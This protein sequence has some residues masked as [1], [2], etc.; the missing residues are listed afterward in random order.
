MVTINLLMALAVF[1]WH[2]YHV[3]TTEIHYNKPQ[4]SVEIS[5]KLFTGDFEKT[6]KE[7]CK[8]SIDLT[9]PK[10]KQSV[11]KQVADYI[12]QNLGISLNKTKRT[13]QFIGYQQE[14]ENTWC[15]FEIRDVAEIKDIEISNSILYDFEEEQINL[16]HFSINGNNKTQKLT[17]PQKTVSLNY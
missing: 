8:C 1:M 15:Y 11:E 3:S 9:R 4:Q 12:Y 6:L 17:Y 7:N 14:E 13:L 16:V 2:P 5:I 10:N